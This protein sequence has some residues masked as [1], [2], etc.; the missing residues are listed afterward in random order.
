MSFKAVF[1]D[2]DLTL[3]NSLKTNR[4]VYRAVC[5]EVNRKQTKQGFREFI[6]RSIT[7]NVNHFYKTKGY[8]GTKQRIR[9]VLVAEFMKNLDLIKVY[10]AKVMRDL[11]RAGIKT[12]I[13]TGNSEKVVMAVAKKH[14]MPYDALYGDEHA[15]GRSKMWAIRQLLKRFK[16]K[17]TDVVYVGD[18]VNDIRQAHLAGVKSIITPSPGIYS[19]SY[20]KKFH[21]DFYCSNLKCVVKMVK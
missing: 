12:A 3:V 13:I 15:K 14:R 2:W 20:L 16:L 17:K 6:G 9:K 5:K 18:H 11:K 10:D 21:P 4:I 8:K 19:R 7:H 1:F